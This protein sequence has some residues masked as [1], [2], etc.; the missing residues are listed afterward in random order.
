MMRVL[1]LG[2]SLLDWPPLVVALRRWLA[3]Q[4][5]AMNVLVV[6]G[7]ELAEAIR[8]LDAVHRLPPRDAHWL[9]AATMQITARLF[10]RLLAESRGI[11]P[12]ADIA[13]Q[14]RE[15]TGVLIFDSWQFLREVEPTLPGERLPESWDATSDSIAARV[16]AA[17]HA[18]EFVLLK[19]ALPPAACAALDGRELAAAGYVDAA[20]PRIAAGLSC[21][22]CVNLRDERFAECR[23]AAPLN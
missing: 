12:Y 14:R 21:V 22:R 23:L 7:G 10:A 2:G 20:F 17:L 6:G 15:E 9:A 16:A 19:S 1:K 5:P 4:A 8:R 18:D 11:W 13:A 3:L